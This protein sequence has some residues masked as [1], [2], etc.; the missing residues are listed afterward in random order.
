MTSLTSIALLTAQVTVRCMILL[1][2]IPP[3]ARLIGTCDS[4]IA[5]SQSRVLLL[6]TRLIMPNGRSIVLERQPGAD[7]DGYSGLEDQ[8]D[9]HWKELLGAAALPTLLAVGT[10]V[11][12]GADTGAPTATSLRRSAGA[13]E[14]RL[15][16]PVNSWLKLTEAE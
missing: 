16:R 10:E 15:I 12:S 6:W 9:N 8:V 11:N 14:T 5:F 13:R 1:R 4:Q 7:S 2:V 3:G